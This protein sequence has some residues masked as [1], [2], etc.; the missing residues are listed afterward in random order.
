MHFALFSDRFDT[1][2]LI[3]MS[4]CKLQYKQYIVVSLLFV[5][6]IVCTIKRI[7]QVNVKFNR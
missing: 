2:N 5:I 1:V 3:C 4:N 7:F 6:N